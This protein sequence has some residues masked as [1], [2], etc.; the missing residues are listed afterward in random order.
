MI[1]DIAR[2]EII[3]A[4]SHAGYDIP[5]SFSLS[6]PPKK[7]WGDFATNIALLIS[8]LRP[9]LLPREV[10]D[11]VIIEIKKSSYISRAELAGPG[12]INITV[13][14]E[15]Y[16]EEIGK[17][18]EQKESYGQIDLGKG[19]KANIEYVSANPTGPLHI[20]NARGGPI[21]E[22]ISNLFSNFNYDVTREFYIND[23]GGQ[24]DRFARS[25][26]YWYEIKFDDKITFPEG[27]YPGEY[28]KLLSEEIQEKEA[29]EL[30]SLKDETELLQFF[31]REGLRN[32]VDNI[33]ADCKLIDV[34]FD[35][36][37]C[38][39]TY[40]IDGST[41]RVIKALGDSGATVSKEGALWFKRPDD[42]ELQDRESVLRKSDEG[43][44]YTYFADDIAYHKNKFDRGYEVIVDVW[45]A[46]HHGHIP[47]LKAAVEALGHPGDSLHIIL[48]QYV[49]LKSGGQSVKMGK[50]FGNFVTLREIIEEG[51]D[52]DVFKYFILSQNPNTPFDFDIELA[53]DTSDKNPVYYIKYAH[54]RIAGI[55]NKAGESIPA[56]GSSNAADLSLLRS[57]EEIALYK[58]LVK[59]PELLE[60][61]LSDF[62][63]QSIPHYAYRIATLFHNFYTNC[64]VITEDKQLMGARLSLIQATKYVL[65]NALF[66]LGISAPD[67]M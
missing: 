44:S 39:S 54:A 27:G 40:E 16:F 64:Q 58:E 15:F 13:S 51:V 5:A 50:R 33:K 26:Y 10:A 43:G 2:K 30:A 48:Y 38:Q 1:K 14:D 6:E 65:R 49:R 11:N 17:I 31:K 67:R 52:P 19:A 35:N 12:F 45:G 8:Q 9:E 63:V 53:K 59:F 46:N 3:K 18:L 29:K 21:G 4:A 28:I 57:P 60:E 42:P 24:V 66:I 23:I 36:W 56:E 20:G 55:L 34:N 41:D 7:E 32:I 25:L 22:A 47:R 62:Q 37:A 61:T